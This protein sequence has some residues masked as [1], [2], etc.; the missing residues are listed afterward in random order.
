[1]QLGQVQIVASIV[2]AVHGLHET[3][4][5]PEAVEDDDVD[6][7]HKD[8]DDDFNDGADQAPILSMWVSLVNTRG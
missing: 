5:G 7:K 1:V 3:A 6:Q 8:F 4:L 2:S